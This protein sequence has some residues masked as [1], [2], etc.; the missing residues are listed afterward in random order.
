MRRWQFI[1]DASI[2]DRKQRYNETKVVFAVSIHYPQNTTYVAFTGIGILPYT[3]MLPGDESFADI[4]E[5]T[6]QE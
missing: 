4:G 1:G 2:Y 3:K 5:G 6:V